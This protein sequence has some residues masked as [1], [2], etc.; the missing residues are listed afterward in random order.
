MTCGITVAP[1]IPVA[2][3]MLSVPAKPGTNPAAAP[4]ASGAAWKTS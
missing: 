1:R 3:R 4:L 2:S